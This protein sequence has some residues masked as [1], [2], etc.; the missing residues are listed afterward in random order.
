MIN[1][2]VVLSFSF[3]D[4]RLKSAFETY[5]LFQPCVPCWQAGSSYTV[6][7]GY[8]SGDLNQVWFNLT[9]VSGENFCKIYLTRNAK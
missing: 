8:P 9:V 2:T 7:P 3:R 5:V 4:I 6:V 1:A